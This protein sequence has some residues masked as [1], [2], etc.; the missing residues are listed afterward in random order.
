MSTAWIA[1]VPSRTDATVLIPGCQLPGAIAFTLGTAASTSFPISNG[2]NNPKT[3]ETTC[4]STASLNAAGHGL[5]SAISSRR[6][7]RR[8]LGI[9][10]DMKRFSAMDAADR[11]LD[12]T[13][14]RRKRG[15]RHAGEIPRKERHGALAFSDG[16]ENFP[17]LCRYPLRIPT[18]QTRRL[19][20]P[21][22]HRRR[23]R[24][25]ICWPSGL[26]MGN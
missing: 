9:F 4:A 11:F 10:S 21:R 24:S 15:H 2:K 8:T 17:P 3:I 5:P 7:G 22:T 26:S 18:S 20:P 14:A 19:P 25:S 13:P 23:S 6:S 12:D 1:S 16:S